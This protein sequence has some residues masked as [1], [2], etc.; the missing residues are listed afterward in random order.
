MDKTIYLTLIIFFSLSIFASTGASFAAD[1]SYSIGL[2]F[3]KEQLDSSD[4]YMFHYYGGY[5]LLSSASDTGINT[6]SASTG[7]SFS[8]VGGFGGGESVLNMY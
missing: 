3:P 7:D 6:A 5:F 1:R 4:I 2:Y 8:G